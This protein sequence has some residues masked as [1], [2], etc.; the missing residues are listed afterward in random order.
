MT[1]L[2]RSF[3]QLFL[4]I[5]YSFIFY[6]KLLDVPVIAFC[7]LLDEHLLFWIKLVSFF[8]FKQWSVDT[9]SFEIKFI[10]QFVKSFIEHCNYIISIFIKNINLI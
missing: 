4:L 10:G 5:K 1:F 8:N 2:V 6:F 7:K 9:G 3:S